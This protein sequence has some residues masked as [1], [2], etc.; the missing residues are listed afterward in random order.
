[1]RDGNYTFSHYYCGRPAIFSCLY[2]SMWVIP[3]ML[4]ILF[5]PIIYVLMYWINYKAHFIVEI[6]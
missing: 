6:N 2:S 1:V 3:V 5:F 4:M